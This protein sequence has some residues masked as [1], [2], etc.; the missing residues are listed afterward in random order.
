MTKFACR[1]PRH[2]NHHN[3]PIRDRRPRPSADPY[4]QSKHIRALT[5]RVFDNMTVAQV[6]ARMKVHPN[7]VKNWTK[8]AL[9]YL[10]NPEVDEVRKRIEE[11]Q[12]TR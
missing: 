11:I 10:G 7:T 6:A 12:G 5:Y 1:G 4:E 9:A 8:I 2:K 3:C